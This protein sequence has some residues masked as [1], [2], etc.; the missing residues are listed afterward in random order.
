MLESVM[1]DSA[2]P[3]DIDAAW[4]KLQLAWTQDEAHRRFIAF[5]AQR[6]A[7]D[8][9]GRRYRTVRDEDPARRDAAARRLDTVVAAAMEQLSLARQ[10]PAPPPKRRAMWLMVGV[11][12]FIIVRAVLGLLRHGSQ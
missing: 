6:G 4:Q 8:Q 1:D 9:A 7:G 3:R 2:D 12:G 10:R 5:C 11:C